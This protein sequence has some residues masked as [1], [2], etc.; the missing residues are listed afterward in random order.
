MSLAEALNARH[1][2]VFGLLYDEHGPRLYAYCHAVVGDAADDAVRDTFVAAARRTTP[3]PADD[4]GLPV[5]LYTLARAECARRDSPP[6]PVTGGPPPTTLRRAIGRLRREHRDTLALTAILPI[7][8]A[9]EVLGVARDTADQMARMARRRLEQAVLAIMGGRAAPDDDLLTALG[10]GRLHTLVAASVPEPPAGLRERVLAACAAAGRTAGPLVF[11]D[12]GLPAGLD[13]LFGPAEALTR[14][15]PVVTDV[16]GTT[17]TAGTGRTTEHTARAAGPA[18]TSDVTGPA[19]GAQAP[20]TDAG[21]ARAAAGTTVSGGAHARRRPLT[22]V[23]R[24]RRRQPVRGPRTARRNRIR[25]RRAI[26]ETTLLAACVA[27]T[28]VGVRLWPAPNSADS[29]STVNGST[30]LVPRGASTDR[31][32]PLALQKEDA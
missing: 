17:G 10:R 18:G 26:A 28:V 5:W 30:V 11:G 9:A 14:P 1:P 20:R 16:S 7:E 6:S 12:D 13:A 3:L 24:L 2:K 31:P 4:A 19:Q 15:Q 25:R 23:P 21:T 32:G 29:T 27:A 8:E 22:A